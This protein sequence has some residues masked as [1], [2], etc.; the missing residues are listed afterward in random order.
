MRCE[1]CDWFSKSTCSGLCTNPCSINCGEY[2]GGSDSCKKWTK[3]T[4]RPTD[5]STPTAE[6][7]YEPTPERL[8]PSFLIQFVR[9]NSCFDAD[10]LAK[11]IEEWKQFKKIGHCGECQHWHEETSYCEL[12]SYFMD[13]EGLCC[14]PAESPSWMMWEK[15]E[16][17]SRFERRTD[18]GKGNL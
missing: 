12:N 2:V 7:K 17:C 4:E 15:E 10:L 1:T 18:D 11:I 13:S 3:K 14:S 8:D 9:N 6:K 16:F 5:E